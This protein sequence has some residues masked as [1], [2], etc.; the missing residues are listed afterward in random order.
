[1]T[2]G[3]DDSGRGRTSRALHARLWGA[4]ARDWAEVQE[5]VGRPMFEAALAHAGTGPGVR[6]LDAGC[7]SGIAAA[8]AADRGASVWGID[9]SDEM[10]AIARERVP[11]GRFDTGDLQALPYEAAAFDVVT[12]FNSFQFAADP[13]AALAEAAR[14]VRPGGQVIV[15]TWG[16]P[17]G[18]PAAAV[19]GALR[20]LLPPPPPGTPGPF[21]LSDEGALRGFAAAAGLAPGEVFDV[22]CPFIYPDEA[23]ALRGLCSTGVAERGRELAGEEA[24]AAAYRAAIAPF[25]QHDGGFRIDAT[26]R[27]LVASRAA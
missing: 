18:M 26:F 23:T 20:T 2:D 7:G 3:Q 24:V 25:R 27:C 9:A 16:P 21:A 22:A 10:I 1:M 15:V 13:V 11:Q 4:R 12:G 8:M 5:G 14:V 6:L 17:E 19:V